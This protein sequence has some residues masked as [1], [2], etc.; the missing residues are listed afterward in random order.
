M[1]WDRYNEKI[2][3]DDCTV[4]ARLIG[5]ARFKL[6]NRINH[7]QIKNSTVLH[8]TFFLFIYNKLNNKF[9]VSFL[10]D[11]ANLSITLRT[12]I[13]KPI[14][15]GGNNCHNC[16]PRLFAPGAACNRHPTKLIGLYFCT[17][18]AVTRQ[19]ISTNITTNYILSV[20]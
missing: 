14:G 8:S 16:L 17:Y 20:F 15:G 11:F 1:H 6:Y 4:Q 18:L 12:S 7:R 5:W 10:F 19:K 2:S 13:A 9:Y 3:T